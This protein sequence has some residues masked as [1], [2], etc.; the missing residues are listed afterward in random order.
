[1]DVDFY[2]KFLDLKLNL[3]F[4]F[5]LKEL[6]SLIRCVF[7]FLLK[8]SEIKCKLNRS[9]IKGLLSIE[10]IRLYLKVVRKI[11]HLHL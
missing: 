1:M 7:E 8:Y 4:R 3:A 6:V 11:F 10:A 2:R 5:T 9:F